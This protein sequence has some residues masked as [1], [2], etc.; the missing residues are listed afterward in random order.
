MP[1]YQVAL[2]AIVVR[3]VAA[4]I[5]HEPRRLALNGVLHG[6]WLQAE[7]VG[8][9]HRHDIDSVVDGIDAYGLTN[10]FSVAGP[11]FYDFP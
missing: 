3:N 9:T 2:D 7:P 8:E 1:S 11:G 10:A 4:A 5:T 6:P